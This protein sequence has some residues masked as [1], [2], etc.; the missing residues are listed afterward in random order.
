M[1]LRRHKNGDYEKGKIEEVPRDVPSAKSKKSQHL[2]EK[3]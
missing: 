1:L 3:S 2:W